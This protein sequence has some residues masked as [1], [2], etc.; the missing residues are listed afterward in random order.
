MDNSNLPKQIPPD[1]YSFFWD[2]DATKL[3]PSK[4]AEYVINRLL[5]KGNIDAA[6]WILQHFPKELIVETFKTMRDFSPWNGVFWARYLDIPEKEVRCLD[7]S[8]LA[9]RRQHWPY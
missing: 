4:H 6:R 8:Y 2:V 3:D 7:P 9:L 5:D 1:L